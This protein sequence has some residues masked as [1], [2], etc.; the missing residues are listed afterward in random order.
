MPNAEQQILNEMSK[1]L[2]K[3]GYKWNRMIKLKLPNSTEFRILSKVQ[4]KLL[5]R[6]TNLKSLASLFVL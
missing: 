5:S 4:I 3:Q 2:K 1:M 6:L